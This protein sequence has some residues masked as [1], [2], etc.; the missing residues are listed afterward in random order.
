M[1]KYPPCPCPMSLPIPRYLF[2][3]KHGMP[4][5]YFPVSCCFPILVWEFPEDGPLPGPQKDY[6]AETLSVSDFFH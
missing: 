6:G 2:L 3:H 5:V 1:L 4:H